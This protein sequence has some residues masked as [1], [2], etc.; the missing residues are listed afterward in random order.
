[1]TS[2]T[3]SSRSIQSR[4]G[5]CWD[6][7]RQTKV[8]VAA[9]VLGVWIYVGDCLIT[10][11]ACVGLC[12][13]LADSITHAA[14]GVL[15]WFL[16]DPS[17]VEWIRSVRQMSGELQGNRF[18]CRYVSPRWIIELHTQSVLHDITVMLHKEMT[19]VLAMSCLI[20]LDHFIEAG[21]VH[22]EDA[23]S[24]DH[25]PF[26]HQLSLLLLVFIVVGLLSAWRTG[27]SVAYPWLLHL[28]RDGAR[29]GV[30]LAG[31]VSLPV[32]PYWAYWGMTM[33]LPPLLYMCNWWLFGVEKRAV[34][35]QLV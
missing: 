33:I 10:W 22:L 16:F 20:D 27:W 9:V 35:V 19:V 1:M 28:I 3:R 12:R 8:L 30:W 25:R 6:Y 4:N 32:I 24:L 34:Q 31:V 14:I 18:N 13:A 2:D 5:G 21:S 17:S 26:A 15:S 29:R 7:F 23:T 11:E